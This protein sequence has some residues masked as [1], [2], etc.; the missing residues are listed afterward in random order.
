LPAL[1]KNSQ[2]CTQKWQLGRACS[3]PPQIYPNVPSPLRVGCSL[4]GSKKLVRFRSSSK[5]FEEGKGNRF[6][7]SRPSLFCHLSSFP[8][9][10]HS[11]KCAS[12]SLFLIF[13]QKVLLL[14]LFPLF[15]LSS[16]FSKI[17][18]STSAVDDDDPSTSNQLM[19]M[20]APGGRMRMSRKK[21]GI[22]EG[23]DGKGLDGRNDHRQCADC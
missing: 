16:G 1:N 7:R 2:I 17:F 20:N 6:G 15:R 9:L 8:F 14:V 10:V 18:K 12:P 4:A 13:L 3:C 5:M 23:F 11:P 19:E 22:Y 21:G